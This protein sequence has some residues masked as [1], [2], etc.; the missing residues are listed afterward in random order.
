V[1]EAPEIWTPRGTHVPADVRTAM[2]A[3]EA[4]DSRLE[5]GYDERNHLWCVLWKDGPQ[6]A[7]FPIFSLG[8]ELPGY[9]QIQK[10]LWQGDTVRRGG[11]VVKDVKARNEEQRL[12]ASADM[13]ERAG[14]VA[15][16]LEYTFRRMG[17]AQYAK[18]YVPGKD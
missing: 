17:K 15:E 2:A 6:G 4:Y 13:R 16:H 14:E 8:E 9:E 11:D 18:V 7:P 12:S 10:M 3:V 1:S 5:L